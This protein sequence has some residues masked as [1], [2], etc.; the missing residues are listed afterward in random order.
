MFEG[1]AVDVFSA[2]LHVLVEGKCLTLQKIKMKET[3]CE[4]WNLIR[5]LKLMLCE[6]IVVENYCVCIC[7]IKISILV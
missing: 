5:L 3:A 7:L 2:I 6:I 4:M 1:L